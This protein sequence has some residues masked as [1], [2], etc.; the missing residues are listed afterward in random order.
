MV[1]GYVFEVSFAYYWASAKNEIKIRSSALF[2]TLAS[3]ISFG[4]SVT[5]LF[6]TWDVCFDY[7]PGH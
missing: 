6:S 7:R 1:G 4:R 3:T 2:S 5:L